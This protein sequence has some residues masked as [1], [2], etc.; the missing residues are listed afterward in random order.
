MERPVPVGGCTPSGRMA[1]YCNG[2][3]Y[4]KEQL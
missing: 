1:L 4:G 2:G 3:T